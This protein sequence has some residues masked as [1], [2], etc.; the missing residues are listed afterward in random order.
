M[1]TLLSSTILLPL[2]YRFGYEKA[3]YVFYLMV[4]GLRL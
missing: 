2:S 4:G 1:T 3:K